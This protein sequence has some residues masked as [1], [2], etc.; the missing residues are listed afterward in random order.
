[1]QDDICAG[2]SI[3]GIYDAPGAEFLWEGELPFVAYQYAE[4]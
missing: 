4:F 1:M 3:L 2:F